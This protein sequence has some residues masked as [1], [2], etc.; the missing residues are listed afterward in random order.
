MSSISTILQER[1]ES[2]RYFLTFF[3]GSPTSTAITISPLSLNSSLMFSTEGW[4]RRQ[5]GHHVVQN[6]TRNTF[7]LTVSFVYLSP[8]RVFA[9]KFGSFPRILSGQRRGDTCT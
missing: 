1:G 6:C 2:F 4:S 9:Q 3:F 8:S 7:P 5:Y